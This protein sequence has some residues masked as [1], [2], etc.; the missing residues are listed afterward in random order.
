MGDGEEAQTSSRLSELYVSDDMTAFK[1]DRHLSVQQKL[2]AQNPS[3]KDFK[4][5]LQAE[6][7]QHDSMTRIFISNAKNTHPFANDRVAQA[8]ISEIHTLLGMELSKQHMSDC[9][10]PPSAEQ[11]LTWSPCRTN[12]RKPSWMRA[13]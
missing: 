6:L 2:M 8:V 7:N 11:D 12:M 5:A 10:S 9:P 4:K 13:R 1:I 3:N